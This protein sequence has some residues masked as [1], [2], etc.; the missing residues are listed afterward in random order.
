MVSHHRRGSSG[1]SVRTA[2][3]RRSKNSPT[4][5]A[6]KIRKANGETMA[7]LQT[8][9]FFS[10]APGVVFNPR[11]PN[12]NVQL[13]PAATFV[14]KDLPTTPNSIAPTPTELYEPSRNS[15]QAAR[16]RALSNGSTKRSPL[17]V[18]A[19]TDA[20]S[21]SSPTPPGLQTTEEFSA[22]RLTTILENK[23]I[24]ENSPPPSGTATPV[25]T[26]IHLRGG[27]VVTV[28]PPELTAWQ[29]SIY[30]QGP[31]RLPK[32]V[33]LPRKNSVASM[34]PFQ[35]AIDRVYQS[36]LFVPRR[37]SDDAV[38]DDVCEFFDEFGFHDIGYEGDRLAVENVKVDEVDEMDIDD[39]AD[40]SLGVET[41]RFTTPPGFPPTG[42]ISPIEK[43]VAK[44]V[45]DSLMAKTALIVVLEP[46]LPPPP[47]ENEETLRARGIARLS[48]HSAGRSSHSSRANSFKKESPSLSRRTSDAGP[49]GETA[50]LPLLPPPE[51]SMLDAVLEASQGEEADWVEE[52]VVEGDAGG[53]DWDDDDD[54]EETDVGAS[55]MAPALRKKHA[56]DR[57]LVGRERRNPVAKMKRFVATATT[58]I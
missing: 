19:D 12:V 17:S 4:S 33:I 2:A 5:T 28:T 46:P 22:H 41:E 24:S 51:E 55:W 58:I 15:L 54:V 13:P 25:A 38:V 18:V 39:E 6:P 32:P 40:E 34:E 53:M 29:R 11:R 50:I 52:I 10:N 14:D 36:A 43:V 9:G 44:D 27:S 21:N 49:S 23:S 37:R 57:G 7:M 42:D 8:S 26:Q 16:Q 1:A 56:L 20:K 31:I 47:V 3:L 30:I 35:E 48:Q 45:A